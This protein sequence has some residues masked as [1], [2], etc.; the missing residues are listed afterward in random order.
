ML[1]YTHT[2]IFPIQYSSRRAAWLSMVRRGS[3]MVRRGSVW[4][5]V[6]QMV[7][8]GSV[9][10][11]S[12]CCK[13]G[14]SSIPGS[15]AQ[16][17][18][19]HWAFK[20]W[21][22]GERPQRMAMDKCIVWMWLNECMYVIKK[23]MKNKQKEWHPATKPLIFF[24][25]TPASI[26]WHTPQQKDLQTRGFWPLYAPVHC[27]HSSFSR[28]NTQNRALQPPPPPPQPSDHHRIIASRPD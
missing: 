25:L 17:G 28:I 15:A 11:A 22:D 4:C 21:G 10:S 1:T 20:R 5:G 3:V 12:A 9:G 14:P 16:G 23:N 18:S 13:A 6:A 24:P 7:R 8:R 26:G 27:A 19:S 2:H